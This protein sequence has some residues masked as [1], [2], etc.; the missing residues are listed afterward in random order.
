M[1]IVYCIC[2]LHSF[3]GKLHGIQVQFFTLDQNVGISL[4]RNLKKFFF[5]RLSVF[6]KLQFKVNDFSST[7][8]LPFFQ[9]CGR[10]L[11]FEKLANSQNFTILQYI[12]FMYKQSKN[13]NPAVFSKVFVTNRSQYNSR[14]NFN[15]IPKFCLINLCQQSISHRGP[16]F[17]SKVTTSFKF[18]NLTIASFNSKMQKSF[19]KDS[20]Q[21]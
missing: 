5:S 9:Y 21:V 18:Q 12:V 8:M 7:S 14:N 6:K 15:I 11:S 17:W 2:T 3:C 16:A 20:I 4:T 1:I 13:Q 10:R 19:S